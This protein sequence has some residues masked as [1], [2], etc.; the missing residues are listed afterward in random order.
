VGRY[1]VSKV[2]EWLALITIVLALI[3]GIVAGNEGGEFEW[4]PA[5][6]WWVSGIISAIF[7]FAFSSVL[8]YLKSIANTLHRIE[9]AVAR[10]TDSAPPAAPLGNSKASLGKLNGYKM[11]TNIPE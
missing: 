11:T 6:T 5:I 10:S 9:T 1:Y 2:L 3:V 4:I 7:I 8:D